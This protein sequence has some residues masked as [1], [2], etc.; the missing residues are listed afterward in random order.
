MFASEAHD[1]AA[2]QSPARFRGGFTNMK[3]HRW[4][5]PVSLAFLAATGCQSSPAHRGALA[6]SEPALNVPGDPAPGVV[7]AQPARTVGFVD[8]HPLLAKP[9]EYYES[10]GNNTAVK[11]AAATVVGIPVGIVGELRQIVV[12]RPATPTY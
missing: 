10:S 4:L 11:V 3:G 1:P 6:A 2:W 8:R 5:V 9:R 12:G 7:A